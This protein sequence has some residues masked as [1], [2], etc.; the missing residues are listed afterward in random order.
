MKKIINEPSNV[1]SDMIDGFTQSSRDLLKLKGNFNVVVRSDYSQLKDKVA[2]I[3]GGGSGHEPAHIGYIGRSM[4]TGAVCG[5]V[6]ASPSAK[7]IFMAIKSIG[8][9]MGCILIVKNYMGDIGSFSIA[10]E[11]CKS[12]LPDIRVEIIVVDD[13]IS[14]ILMK[15][16]KFSN[17]DIDKDIIRDKYKTITNRRG[18]AGTVLVHK[19]LGGLAEQGKSIDEILEFYNEFI[20]P[21]KSL[22]LVT[23]GVGLSSCTIPSVGS[24]SFT[25]GEKEMELGLGIHGEF[26]IEKVELKPSK[27]IV[28]SLI[29]NL[30]NILPYSSNEKSLIVLINNLG[31]TTNMEMAIVINDCLNYLNEK[32]FAIERLISGTLMSSLEMSGI[33]ISLLLIKNN[34]IINL[35]DIQT[36]AMGWP[37]NILKPYKNKKDSILTLDENEYHDIN[38]DHLKLIKTSK[39]NGD[40]LK[41]M[42]LLGCNSLIE[43]SNE[44]TELDKLVGD[45]DLG[46]TL[47]TLS[48]SIINSINIIPF[49]QP[50]YAF[51][52]ISS[53]I[54]D[55]IGGSSGLFYSIF[56]LRLSNS[57]YER[58][59]TTNN[60][61]ISTKDWGLSLIDAVNSIKEL[62]K[63]DIGDCTMLDSLIPAINQINNCCFSDDGNNLSFILNTLKLA[64]NEAQL[65]C[66]ST[67]EMIAKKGRSSY[68]GERTTNI[69]DPGAY[70]INIIFK[71]FQSINLNKF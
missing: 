57:L 53:I 13:D 23:M 14:S 36:N 65:G 19:I 8:S 69:M 39:K 46:T 6:F 17:N 67:I 5:D 1:V 51:R 49:D 9:K 12:Q 16:N 60:N 38:Y 30:L 64:S 27:Q 31:S 37:N 3:S 44:L 18:I 21:S 11:M 15:L 47:E 2:L 55:S 61:Q 40:I 28:K 43:N 52:K 45:G 34:Q 59:T 48:K 66:E 24:P 35:I 29:D 62:G 56:F 68:L 33:S 58:L 32:G 70:A 54:Q 50:C 71:S 10:R 4:L 7:Q 42:V 25:L 41:E 63:A 22:N 20:S 26:G